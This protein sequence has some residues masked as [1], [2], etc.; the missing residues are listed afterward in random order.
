MSFREGSRHP[1]LIDGGM[2]RGCVMEGQGEPRENIS[3]MRRFDEE[4]KEGRKGKN[5][6]LDV[7]WRV[8]VQVQD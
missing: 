1:R 7:G 5:W 4:G 2:G 3:K 6:M 8:S